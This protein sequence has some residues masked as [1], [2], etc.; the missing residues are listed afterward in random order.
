MS[1][2]S[3]PVAGPPD[4][5]HTRTLTEPGPALAS[6][7]SGALDGARFVPGTLLGGRYRIVGLLGRG[8]MGEVY[9][10]EDL[11]LGEPVALKFLPAELT[12]DGAAL[13]RFHREVRVARQI[14]HP[15]V[16][17]VFDIG[18]AGG[19]HFLSMEYIDGEDLSGLL[20]RIGR[21]S[22][23]KAVEL[24]R[25]ICA[26]LAAAHEAGVLHRDMKP[27]NVMIDGRGR[28][29]ITDF[30]LAQVADELQGEA[31]F[32]GT[33][34]YMAPEQIRAGEVS[35]ATDLYALGLV[36]YEMFTGERP[37]SRRESH[38]ETPVEEDGRELMARGGHG[39]RRPGGA[40]RQLSPPSG[41]VAGLDPTVEAVILRCLEEEPPKRPASALEVSAAL[42]GGDP[43]AAALAAGETPSPEMVAATASGSL[44][45][46]VAGALLVCCLAALAGVFA[47]A[48]H[49]TV[50][51]LAKPEKPPAVLADRA[52][53]ILAEL[54]RPEPPADASHG[55]S[56]D[57]ERL[58]PLFAPGTRAA[59]RRLPE[60]R[61]TAFYFWYRESS[62]GALAEPTRERPH[63]VEPGTAAL[64]L[65]TSGNLASLVQVPDRASSPDRAGSGEPDW[66][67]L[68]EQAGIDAGS[69][70]PAESEWQPPV[71]ADRRR[72]WRGKP[73]GYSAPIRVEAAAVG[74]QIVFFEVR[75]AVAEGRGSTQFISVIFTIFSLLLVAGVALARRQLRQGRGDRAG[76]SRLA[77]AILAIV[78]LGSLLLGHHT[79]SLIGFRAMLRSLADSLFYAA[80]VWLL[81]IALEPYI[82]RYW[83]RST[84]GWNRLLRG[85]VRDPVV[86]RDLLV[87]TAAST[88]LSLTATAETLVRF[89]L[90]LTP[91]LR[92]VPPYPSALLGWPEAFASVLSPLPVAVFAALGLV[93]AAAA[94]RFWLRWR[95]L[96]D[97]IFLGLCVALG[98]FFGSGVFQAT[99]YGVGSWILILRVGLLSFIPWIAVQ[100]RLLLNPL[101]GDLGAWYG[102]NTSLNLALIAAL[103]VYAYRTSLGP[104]VQEKRL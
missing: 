89:R 51:G 76:A 44:S 45:R 99:L 42:P 38:G 55:L 46:R 24:A 95:W 36:L 4:D 41:D 33:P 64:R 32:A 87:G 6:S 30:G 43:L 65:D 53:S 56:Y 68:L 70:Q 80:V 88:L 3:K 10:A 9:R 67:R 17:R 83:P 84:V 13:A 25:Q 16:C 62:S 20:N 104:Q 15:N 60:E 103:A 57:F 35:I 37:F 22:R 72:A 48:D 49:T 94:L 101:A 102:F 34:A 66:R 85:R 61:P 69:L 97:A 75:D 18:E 14:A 28:A 74:E 82:R 7:S 1:R 73:P 8:G 93:L 92:A 54:G 98:W 19:L 58:I 63:A 52:R 91:N 12:L 78:F 59:W 71:Y 11:K 40:L 23:D 29:K 50:L 2:D 96:A 27:A 47:L 5:D 31:A 79:L 77:L 86:G 81:Y 90:D 100:Q 39:D 21:L 26:G